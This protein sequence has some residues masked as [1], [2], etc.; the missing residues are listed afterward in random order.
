M[1]NSSNSLVNSFQHSFIYLK[2]Y[3]I[4]KP[5]KI[6]AILTLLL[7]EYNIFSN[8]VKHRKSKTIK[9]KTDVKKII[10]EKRLKLDNLCNGI[11]VDKNHSYQKIKANDDPLKN[12]K[13]LLFFTIYFGLF[14]SFIILIWR[15]D[16]E[17]LDFKNPG[18]SFG[19]ALF[20]AFTIFII[21]LKK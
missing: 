6:N 13:D 8:E 16:S 19:I 14:L 15:I 2:S 20:I 21:L 3:F 9:D 10:K 12:F 5:F 11:T 17:Y 4:D 18:I 7:S 1:K